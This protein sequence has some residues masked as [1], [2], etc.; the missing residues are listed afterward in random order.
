L[1]DEHGIEQMLAEIDSR[2]VASHRLVE[3]LG[4]SRTESRT[5]KDHG[6]PAGAS[7]FLFELNTPT[8]H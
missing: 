6:Q 7:E 2:N 4:F 5:A 1:R 3:S 8:N